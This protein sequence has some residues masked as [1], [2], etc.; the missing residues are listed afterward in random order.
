MSG[1]ADF[2]SCT[3]LI[4]KIFHKERECLVESCSFYGVY[5]PHLYNNKFIAFSH[6]S[7][8]ADF[9]AVPAE[10]SL[11]DVRVAAEYVCSLSLEQLDVVFARVQDHYNRVHL[12]FH[13][14]Y[15]LVTLTY[16][17]G[18]PS[19]SRNIIFRQHF[20]GSIIDY[21]T[22]AMIYELNQD[23]WYRHRGNVSDL[24]EARRASQQDANFLITS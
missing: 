9:L 20:G 22:G 23:P 12:C 13:A 18:F 8:I 16:G 24:A 17:F 6:F 4:R 10:A 14:T 15:M 5:Q 2:P 7:Q 11:N 3:Q 19:D 1:S 21:A